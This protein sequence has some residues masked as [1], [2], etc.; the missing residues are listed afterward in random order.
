[1]ASTETSNASGPTTA[2]SWPCARGG[3]QAVLPLAPTQNP[4]RAVFKGREQRDS[5]PR[6]RVCKTGAATRR[7]P[8]TADRRPDSTSFDWAR[9][10]SG[11]PLA[12]RSHRCCPWW[13]PSRGK[14]CKWIFLEMERAGFEPA[15]SD[16]QSSTQPCRLRR[17]RRGLPARPGS[18]SVV[19]R[20]SLGIAG[21]F[22]RPRAGCVR[23]EGID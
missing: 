4:R 5:T 16:L 10:L 23:D 8:T 17:G 2:A 11:G 18:L 13:K 1:V 12:P 14:S 9:Q 15:A 7:H 21:A 22:R 20:G 19:L 3:V 6:P